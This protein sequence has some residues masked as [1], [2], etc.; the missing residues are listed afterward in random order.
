MKTYF[1][2][3]PGI[4]CP[5]GGGHSLEL[6]FRSAHFSPSPKHVIP[7]RFENGRGNTPGH[8]RLSHSVY[9]LLAII[10]LLFYIQIYVLR[11]VGVAQ[12]DP[13]RFTKEQ[14]LHAMKGKHS[15]DFAAAVKS[16]QSAGSCSITLIAASTIVFYRGN[17]HSLRLGYLTLCRIPI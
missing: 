15:P 4:F 1:S 3:A 13:R 8:F 5:R 14:V 12:Q 11:R 9:Q 17:T 2:I 7:L 10:D 16:S 6:G